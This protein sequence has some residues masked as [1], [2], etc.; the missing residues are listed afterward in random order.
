MQS[1]KRRL[2]ILIILIIILAL[3]GLL[4]TRKGQREI[5]TSGS[6]S[7]VTSIY[8]L[9]KPLGVA[10][11][12]DHLWISNTGMG[13]VLRYDNNAIKLGSIDAKDD[14]G[15][16]IVFQSPFGI[17]VDNDRN[18]IYVCDYNWRGVRAFTKD[19]VFLF[20]IPRD[21]KAMPLNPE[22]GWAPYDAAVYRDNI[23]VTSKDGIYVF[24]SE[25]NFQQHWGTKGDQVGQFDFANG[26]ATDPNNGNIYVADTGNRRV[27]ALTPTGEVRWLLGAPPDA[28]NTSLIGLPRAIFV[29]QDGNIFVT[30]TFSHKILVIDSNGKLI[31]EFGDRGTADAQFDF[32][33]GVSV[34]PSG[35]MYIADRENGRVQVWQISDDLPKIDPDLVVKFKSGLTKLKP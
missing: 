27:V 15:E 30:D 16:Q 28:P 19:G 20:N 9:E 35:R 4:L 11:D 33:E 6:F 25:G 3:I 1:N 12:D 2:I 34:T 14:N 31:S 24:D 8:G 22:L 17:G 5:L 13:E 23:Y 29:A 10:S 18:R 26:I 21:P 7:F 32:P